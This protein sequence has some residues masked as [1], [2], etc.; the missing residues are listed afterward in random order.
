MKGDSALILNNTQILESLDWIDKQTAAVFVEFTLFN[1]NVNLFQ[2]CQILF[3]ILPSGNLVNSAQFNSIDLIDMNNSGLFTFKILMNVIYMIFIGIFMFVEIK[4]IVKLG[5]KYFCQFNNYLELIIIAFSWAAFSMYIYRL[6]S[7]YD[8]YKSIQT[9]KGANGLQNVFINLQYTI[10]CDQLLSYFI[11]FCAAFGSLR[12]VKLLR[13]C[14][15]IVVFM[16]AF[17]K[18]LKELISFAVVFFI[19]WLSFV[20]AIYLIFNDQSSQFSTFQRSMASCFQI[21]L[22]QFNANT[23]YNSN[24]FLAPTIFI[25]YNICI[26]FIMV[27]TFITILIENYNSARYDLVLDSEDPEL[28]SYLKSLLRSVFFCSKAKQENDEPVY[29]DYWNTLPRKFDSFVERIQN[30]RLIFIFII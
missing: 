14:K 8:I 16:I 17:K 25:A 24:T 19:L 3:E 5:R 26:V 10:N 18:C 30:V 11:G 6:Y 12:F 20:Q 2:Y 9:Q 4:Q 29:L 21:I 22:G 15:Q 23:F 28:F 1:P 27:S 13:F 7:S